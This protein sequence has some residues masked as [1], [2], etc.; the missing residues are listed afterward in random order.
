MAISGRPISG[1]VGAGFA[2]PGAELG[3]L[4]HKSWLGI[5]DELPKGAGAPA[6]LSPCRPSLI[7]GVEL[8]AF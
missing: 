4:G 3:E 6:P 8:P 5:K 1:Q 2:K 7:L